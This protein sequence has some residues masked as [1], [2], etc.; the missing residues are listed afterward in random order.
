[1]QVPNISSE[2][3]LDSDIKYI[4]LLAHFLAL[5][6]ES[7]FKMN[8]IQFFIIQSRFCKALATS[9]FCFAHSWQRHD[10]RA[11]LTSGQCN[12]RSHGTEICH[13]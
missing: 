5:F 9:P 4:K 10:S 2:T 11:T 1:M 6:L 12:T 13:L 7:Q 8:D 3:L